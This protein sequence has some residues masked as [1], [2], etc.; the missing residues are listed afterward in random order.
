MLDGLTILG[1][2]LGVASVIRIRILN[3]SAI[4]SFAAGVHSIGSRADVVV[5]GKGG[6]L[7]D[8]VYPLVRGTQGVSAAWPVFETAVAL[9]GGPR[10]FLRLL[11]VDLLTPSQDFWDPNSR[12]AANAQAGDKDAAA[13][14]A[15][16]H[17]EAAM[18]A[19]EAEWAAER[20]LT[21][22]VQQ[23]AGATALPLWLDGWMETQDEEYAEALAM[24]QL[25]PRP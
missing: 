2:A 18:A 9:K 24:R 10:A 3:Q 20:N 23:G 16:R 15:E 25:L 1:V 5:T 22:A 19:M 13:A 11:G 4:A 8:M 21:A 7:S 6:N 14:K 12:P 17:A